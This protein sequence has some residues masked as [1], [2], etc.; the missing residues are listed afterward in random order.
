MFSYSLFQAG[1][2][3]THGGELFAAVPFWQPL[4][5]QCGVYEG[6]K[7]LAPS[8]SRQCGYNTR[9]ISA[10]PTQLFF[11]HTFNYS[12]LWH[13]YDTD[14]SGYIEA[15]ELKASIIYLQYVT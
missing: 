6:M 5:I 9:I 1:S 10:S 8:I 12:Q 4:R 11:T 13:Q 3:I 2:I 7:L 15:D 14:N